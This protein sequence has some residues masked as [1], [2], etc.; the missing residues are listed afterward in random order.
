MERDIEGGEKLCN[1]Q[2]KLVVRWM[3]N[4]LKETRLPFRKEG[5]VLG[6]CR[7][8]EGKRKEA[9]VAGGCRKGEGKLL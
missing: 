7:K 5:G 9:G 8:G 3:Q 2:K 1:A 4:S 6:G